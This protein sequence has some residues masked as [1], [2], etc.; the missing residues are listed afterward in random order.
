MAFV[1]RRFARKSVQRANLSNGKKRYT[2]ACRVNLSRLLASIAH[3]EV[4][5]HYK[6]RLKAANIKKDDGRSCNVR[7]KGGILSARGVRRDDNRWGKV[8]SVG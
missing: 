3:R 1:Y 8:D 5:K 6:C 7:M 2:Y 4:I